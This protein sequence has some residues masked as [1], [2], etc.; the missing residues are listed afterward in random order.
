[1]TLNQLRYFCN[2]AR[3]HSITQAAKLMFV[4]QP[5]VSSA[6]RELE[7]EFS[8]TLFAYTN[9]R[10]ELT[11]E[12]EQF[13][14]RASALLAASDE[15]QLEFQDQSRR[16]PTVRLGIPP[17][18]STVFFPELM[19]AFHQE[20][21]EIYLE[22]SE[23]GS[24]RACDMVQ[25]EQLDLGLVNLELYAVDKL[26]YTVL[27]TDRLLFCVADNHPLAGEET[28]DLRRLDQEPIILF[29]RDSVQNQ[30]LLQHFHALGVQPRVIMHSSQIATTMKFVN[31]GKCGCFFFSSMLPFTPGIRGI[32]IQ[33][34]I[35]TRIGLVWKKGKYIS[36]YT[37]AF[38]RF[39]EKYYQSN[40]LT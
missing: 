1:M 16:R 23:Y 33:P 2:A 31:Q 12:G 11:V 36:S 17:N 24:V 29:N 27:A 8:M 4:T 38:L 13:Y 15:L 25:N 6:I 21:P 3:C 22:L 34:E 5:A 40:P 35:P 9:N 39:C 26:E 20:H 19:D 14:E 7:K 32:P 18:L 30:L 28:L 10:L 37:Q